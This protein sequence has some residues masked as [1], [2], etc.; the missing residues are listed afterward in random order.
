MIAQFKRGLYLL[1]IVSPSFCHAMDRAYR[2]L[3]AKNLDEITQNFI[4]TNEISNDQRVTKLDF[5]KYATSELDFFLQSKFG[6]TYDGHHPLIDEYIRFFVSRP[7]NQ[8]Q[9]WFT[10]DHQITKELGGFDAKPHAALTHQLLRSRLNYP[11]YHDNESLLLPYPI[12]LVYGHEKNNYMDLRWQGKLHFKWTSAYLSVLFDALDRS[13][14]AFSSVVLGA[15]T[16]ARIDDHKKKSYWE[17]YEQIRHP[18]RDFYP[19]MLAAAFVFH[20]MEKS[21]MKKLH[22]KPKQ[23]W[24]QVT[25]VYAIHLD[26]LGYELKDKEKVLVQRNKIYYKRIV[27]PNSSISLPQSLSSKFQTHEVE[28]GKESTYKIHNIKTPH[29]LVSYMM[30][31]EENASLLAKIFNTS[32][33]EILNINNLKDSTT[34]SNRVLFIKVPI[35]D[36]TFYAGF[37]TLSMVQMQEQITLRKEQFIGWPEQHKPRNTESNVQ[38]IHVVKTGDTLGAIGRKYKVSVNQ[39]MQWNNLKSTSIQIGQKLVIKK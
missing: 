14:Q 7:L 39:I 29:A 31:R 6:G 13:S 3:L 38:Q 37:D 33:V 15:A 27:P 34:F 8:L 32:A 2:D 11:D 12:C 30:K 28:I 5:P 1:L 18:S 21:G 22:F 25:S 19:A 26:V 16:V 10:L 4:K 20:I 35:K 9:L 24:V 17:L 36:S 23:E